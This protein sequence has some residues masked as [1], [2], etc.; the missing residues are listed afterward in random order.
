MQHNAVKDAQK[1][2]Q[3]TLGLLTAPE[4]PEEI[5]DK[6]KGSLP[7]LLK[8]YVD[9]NVEWTIR[10]LTD[11]LSGSEGYSKE[12][13][14][15]LEKV[16]DRENWDL[17]ISVTDLPIFFQRRL[18]VSDADV[19]KNIAYISIPALGAAPIKKRVREAVI[20]LTDEMHH[21]AASEDREEREGEHSGGKADLVEKDRVNKSS[22]DL[23]KRRMT[24]RISPIK[25]QSFARENSNV[26]VRYLVESRVSGFIRM[27][28][29]M[30]LANRPWTIFP[31]FKK[32]LATAF[33]TGAYGLIFPNLWL[34][35]N[36][37]S[38]TR[39]ITM[40]AVAITAMVAWIIVV[41]HLWEEKHDNHSRYLA[42]L[43]NAVTALTL[44]IGV[45]FYYVMLYGIFLITV[46]LFIP[47]SMLEYELGRAV[48]PGIFFVIAW[49]VTSVATLVG[50][51][52]AGL[53]SE[54]TILK[55][56]YGHRQQIRWQQAKERQD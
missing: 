36:S 45:L 24:E 39:L 26:D 40:M 8:Q 55:A 2:K 27:I 10:T 7:K 18:I 42:N 25:R 12:I 5:I 20:Q 53:E 31:A 23:T 38:M 21:G 11:P 35:S 33:A 47:P 44:G 22:Q 41:H 16:K 48:G 4:L 15:E 1:E 51:I 17:I 43:Y 14:N 19:K 46:V 50:A 56:T 13:M 37:Y 9:E 34:L 32:V 30:V 49:L 29:G 54:N 3:L 52:G 6:M 28:S